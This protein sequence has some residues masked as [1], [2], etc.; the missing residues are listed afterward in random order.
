MSHSKHRITYTH[1]VGRCEMLHSDE[2][3]PYI[4]LA[5]ANLPE[6]HNFAILSETAKKKL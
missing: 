4:I 2:I 3:K 1:K 5:R 6:T